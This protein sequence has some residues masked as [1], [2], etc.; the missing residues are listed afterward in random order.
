MFAKCRE[1]DY[2]SGD[3]DSMEEIKNKIIQDGG[4]FILGDK[5]Y[6]GECPQCKSKYIKID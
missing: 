6:H 2:D 4:S 1:C 5:G 3:F